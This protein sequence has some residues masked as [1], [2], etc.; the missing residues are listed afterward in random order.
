MLV[1]SQ[2]LKDIDS[3]KIIKRI[4]ESMEEQKIDILITSEIK[5]SFVQIALEEGI[6]L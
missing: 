2:H 1:L 3:I 6:E 4:Y 5:D